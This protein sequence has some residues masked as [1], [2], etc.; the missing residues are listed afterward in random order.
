MHNSRFARRDVAQTANCEEKLA[1]LEDALAKDDLQIDILKTLFRRI[2]PFGGRRRGR[3]RPVDLKGLVEESVA[4]MLD[5]A[6]EHG[7]T[8]TVEAESTTATVDQSEI[9]IVVVNLVENAIYWVPPIRRPDSTPKY[10]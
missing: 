4:T 3:P 1:V 2:Q 5:E 10:G 9:A 6:A 7:V 8:L